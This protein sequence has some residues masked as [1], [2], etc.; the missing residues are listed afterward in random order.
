MTASSVAGVASRGLELLG[1][2]WSGLGGVPGS[3][4]SGT[5]QTAVDNTGGLSGDTLVDALSKG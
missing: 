3:A 4:A 5:V 1:A 2:R